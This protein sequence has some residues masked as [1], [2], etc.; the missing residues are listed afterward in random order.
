MSFLSKLGFGR[1]PPQAPPLPLPPS[2]VPSDEKRSIIK[3]EIET[4]SYASEVEREVA[5]K[6]ERG[7]WQ[8]DNPPVVLGA[9][10]FSFEKPYSVGYKVEV[11]IQAAAKDVDSVRDLFSLE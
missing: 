5:A 3:F 11:A 10:M 7:I 9:D 2:R 6:L 8:G 4:R 1:C